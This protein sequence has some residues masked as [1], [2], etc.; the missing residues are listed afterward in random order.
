LA[1]QPVGAYFGVGVGGRVPAWPAYIVEHRSGITEA[2][3][4]RSTD[5]SFIDRDEAHVRAE[6][7]SQAGTVVVARIEHHDHGGRYGSG[8]CGRPDR[9]NAS[10]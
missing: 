9:V 2:G 3:R 4:A 6:S 10:S 1:R 7:P 5:I 8:G